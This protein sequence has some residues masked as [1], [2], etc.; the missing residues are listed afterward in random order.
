MSNRRTF[1]CN[2]ASTLLAA[3]LWTLAAEPRHRA[4]A[5]VTGSREPDLK[6][7]FPYFK[8]TPVPY[9]NVRLHDS[10]W[11]PRQKTTREVTIPW[12]TK[13]HD[14]A[15][16]L[17]A[18]EAHPESYRAAETV[19]NMESI[20]LIEAMATVVGLT[21]D[22]GIKGLTDAWIKPLI[23]AQGAD[24]YLE[25]HFPP[26]LARPPERWQAV[27]WSHEAYTTG[28]YIES[29]IAFREATG[30]EVMY[31]S[32]VRAADN[33]VVDLLSDKHVYTSGHPEI[34]QALM[35]LYGQTGNIHYL[36]LCKWFLDSRGH[37]AG[38]P[39]FG[40][41]RL[42][43][44]PVKEQRTIEGHAVMAAYLWNGVTQYVGATGDAAYREAVLSVWDDFANH[45]MYIHGGGGNVSSR[46]E[47]YRKAPDCILPDDAYCE[48]C[49]VFANFQWAHSLARLTGEARYLD[50]AERMLYNAFCASLSL[51]GDASS[52]RNLI[53]VNQP[54]PRTQEFATSCCPPNIVK[55]INKVGGFFYFTDDE[56]IYVNHYGASEAHIPWRAGVQ[57]TQTTEYPWNG[58]IQIRVEPHSPGTFTLRLR[59]PAWA[60]SPTLSVNG[61]RVEGSVVQGWL[62]V[63]RRWAA[64]DRVDL[65][66]PM[67]IRRVTMPPRFKEY[68]NR[69]ALERGPIVYCLEEQDVELNSRHSE[70]ADNILAT[71]YIPQDAR[72]TAEHRSELLGGVTVLR[73]EVRQLIRETG[74]ESRPVRVTLVPYGVWGNRTAGAMRIWLGAHQ[75]PLVEMLLPEQLLGESCVG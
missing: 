15:G 59:V 60:T 75:A 66:L 21:P 68:E 46:I 63:R 18:F 58:T 65:I 3:H 28:H 49:S 53:Q 1:V 67:L 13:A 45:R 47:G 19:V 41:M 22:K 51:S 40:R 71:F 7:R 70:Y 27:W 72:F 55:L 32:A 2:A 69:A 5:A 54:T 6:Q 17:A 24:G 4:P 31:A 34:E 37:H 12:L 50:V 16:G 42:D 11:S 26:G 36:R 62:V 38:R 25:E 64:G 52:Y 20:K 10:F 14:R 73:G 74:D 48:S 9:W 56:G 30:D 33:M 29:A 44:K 23:H 8:S 57:L 35:R 39:S 61:Q 43:D